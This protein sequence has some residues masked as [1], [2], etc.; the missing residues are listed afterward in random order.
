MKKSC[1]PRFL[2]YLVACFFVMSM[3]S[4][5]KDFDFKP[6]IADLKFSEQNV[7]LNPVLNFSNSVTYLV[8][9]YNSSNVDIEIP[10]IYLKKR[11]T[12]YYR[13][14]VDGRA[15]YEFAN[16][17]LRAKDSLTIFVSLAAEKPS[18][19]LYKDQIVFQDLIQNKEINILA[20]IAKAKYYTPEKGK[21]T[22]I[23][24][25]NT[26]FDKGMYHVISGN[27][28]VAEGKKLSIEAGT[29]VLFYEN[30]VLT[31]APNATLEIK[32]NLESPVVFKT[33][34]NEIK[35][36][37]IP[38]Q[39]K[40]IN[41]EQNSHLFLNYAEIIGA[42]NA[43]KMGQ[44]VQASIKNTKIY[45]SGLNSIDAENATIKAENLVINN[46]L[47]NG[48]S[49]KNGGDY[50]FS[51]CS[52]ANFWQTG[53]WGTGENIPL[54]ASNYQINTANINP[55]T[56]KINNTILYGSA[57]NGLQLDLKDRIASSIEIRNSLIKND[58]PQTL[59]LKNPIFK[60][61]VTQNPNF[62]NTNFFSPDLGLRD[63]SPALGK[64]NVADVKDNQLTIEGKPRAISPNLGA[65]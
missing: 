34:K 50:E 62:K 56:L 32:G 29:K 24:N 64:G 8:K 57:S 27:L 33:Y 36:D 59:D 38:S 28:M 53:A 51:F 65:Y 15:G 26:T 39:W 3:L 48:I 12:S 43:L 11:Q 63:N 21:K 1:F 4:C 6:S 41:L 37:T 44:G 20:L 14:N 40:G 13:I 23:L 61:I 10:T 54:Y 7:L 16:V 31:A 19:D 18:V 22:I 47:Q 2:F 58:N 35:Y 55:L 5:R 46:A 9:V 25:E 52:I 17:P 60:D 42:E 49:L 30:G 45:N